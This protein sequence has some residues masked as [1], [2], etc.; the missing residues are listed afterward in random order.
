VISKQDHIKTRVDKALHMISQSNKNQSMILRLFPFNYLWPYMDSIID[1]L[2]T[3]NFKFIIIKRQN[4]EHQL[5]SFALARATGEWNLSIARASG[6]YDIKQGGYIASKVTLQ[7]DNC[8][9]LETLYSYIVD[10]DNILTR[11]NILGPTIQYET[12]ISDMANILN[13]KANT[14]YSKFMKQAR[15]DPYDSIIN[16]TE[17]KMFIEN[18]INGT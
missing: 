11:Y 2:K 8:S 3:A 17:I 10:V 18:I 16:A 7:I 13:I 5:L 9:Y 6:K 15:I 12:G 14:M 1:V 4:I